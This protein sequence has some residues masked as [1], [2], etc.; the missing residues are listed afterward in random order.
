MF[1]QNHLY[2]SKIT[3]MITIIYYGKK[4]TNRVIQLVMYVNSVYETELESIL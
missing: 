4:T 1:Y 3:R 2:K